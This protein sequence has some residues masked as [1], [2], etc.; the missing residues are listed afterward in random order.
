MTEAEADVHHRDQVDGLALYETLEN[1]VIPTFYKGKKKF[2][3]VF[4]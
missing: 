1:K 2:S 3:L 4:E